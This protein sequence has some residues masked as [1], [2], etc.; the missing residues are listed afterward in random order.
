MIGDDV[1]ALD[2]MDSENVFEGRVWNVRRDTVSY[3]DA[4]M[5]RDY[6]VHPGA[7]GIIAIN[8]HADLL[9]V[10]Q[11]RHPMGM[12]MWEPPAGL[13]DVADESALDA[14]KR[15]LLEETGY[16]A[17]TWN[18]LVDF[19]NTPGGSTEMLRCFLAQGLTEHPQGR[20]AR[21]DE[22]QDMPIQW[23]PV[24]EVLEAIHAG[25]VTNVLLVT[26]TLA[27]LTA[28]A[29]PQAL[30]PPDAAWPA[31]NTLLENNRIFTPPPK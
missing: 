11:Y 2:V 16:V 27:L 1:V 22:E 14:A 18:V 26:G 21:Y 30:R 8:E 5:T 20:P 13:L 10:N 15:E 29:Q 28:L 3:N 12:K 7:V 6:V 23:V 4:T 25:H 24:T 19:A 9:L 17:S 31:R